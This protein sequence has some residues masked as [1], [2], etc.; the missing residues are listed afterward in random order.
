MRR[1]ALVMHALC[2][3][4]N[5][6][7]FCAP[8]QPAGLLRGSLALLVLWGLL[9]GLGVQPAWAQPAEPVAGQ[10]AV[11]VH[12]AVGHTV[13]YQIQYEALDLTV[14][15]RMHGDS[16][17]VQFS[18]EDMYICFYGESRSLDYLWF[19]GRYNKV[20]LKYAHEDTLYWQYGNEFSLPFVG[21]SLPA[22]QDSIL[23]RSC[24]KLC[25]VKGFTGSDAFTY[26]SC[27]WYCPDLPLNP[28]AF[29]DFTV[30]QFNMVM[31]KM[32]S[33]FLR[34]SLEF[35]YSH[36]IIWEAMRIEPGT[37]IPDIGQQPQDVLMYLT[38]NPILY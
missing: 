16:C 27:Y 33:V 28:V 4:I 23:N 5:H 24:R 11:P 17:T 26:T 12:K 3:R 36:R 19:S 29:E 1:C 2:T 8:G 34:Y 35:P 9:S 32:Q 15:I 22:T 18:P 6:P 38:E 10:A 7:P 13:H 30:N 21:M 37:Q 25:V 14:P 31:R 20:F